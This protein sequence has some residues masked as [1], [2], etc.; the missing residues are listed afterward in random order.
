MRSAAKLSDFEL[1]TDDLIAMHREIMHSTE[2]PRSLPQR[3]GTSGPPIVFDGKGLVE[4]ALHDVTLSK[5]G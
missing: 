5:V 4:D 1:T 3:E 2:N